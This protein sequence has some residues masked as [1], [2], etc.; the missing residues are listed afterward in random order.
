MLAPFIVKQRSLARRPSRRNPAEV[1]AS[2][3]SAKLEEGDFKGAPSF[4]YLV[5]KH[6]APHPDAVIPPLQS[7]GSSIFV[8]EKEILFSIKSFPNGCVGGPDRLRPQYLKDMICEGAGS[9]CGALLSALVSFVE[10]ILNGDTT[11]CVPPIS[12]FSLALI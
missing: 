4:S 12:P 8:C 2:R 10:L 9:G 3:V 5:E 11:T 1:L 6:P 7:N